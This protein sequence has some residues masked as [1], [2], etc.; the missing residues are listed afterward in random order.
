[1][2]FPTQKQESFFA[3]HVQA[4]QYFG[5]VPRRLT[6]DNLT[7]AV[8]RVLKGRNRQEQEAFI[9]FRSHHLFESHFCTPGQGHE[10]GG[11]EHGVGYARR[12]FMVPI[13]FLCTGKY[14]DLEI[15][16]M[17]NLSH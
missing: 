14:V 1:M 9:V 11:V 17:S 8:L 2:A 13:P 7:T 3:G 16:I 12:N 10:K 4:F 5:G 15:L 6:Y